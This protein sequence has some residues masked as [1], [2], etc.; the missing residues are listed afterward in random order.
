MTSEKHAIVLR[1]KN[2]PKMRGAP[3]W[4]DHFDSYDEFLAAVGKGQFNNLEPKKEKDK[5]Q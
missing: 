1:M 4:S 3:H 2:A 5:K